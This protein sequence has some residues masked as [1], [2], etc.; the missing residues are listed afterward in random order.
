MIERLP[1][2]LLRHPELRGDVVRAAPQ[3]RFLHQEEQRLELLV[4]LERFE[5]QALDVAGDVVCSHR[6]RFG[7]PRVSRCS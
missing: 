5:K 6:P 7:R 3:V 2:R 4:A 1:S